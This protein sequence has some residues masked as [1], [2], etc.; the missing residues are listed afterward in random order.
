MEYV[1]P[2]L[3]FISTKLSGYSRNR[4][5]LM[6][7]TGDTATAGRLTTFNLPENA[8]IDTHNLKMHFSVATTGAVVNAATVHARLPAN[9]SSLISRLEVSINGVSVQNSSA[10]YNSICRL[11]QIG[12]SNRDRNGSV[13]RAL[14]HGAINAADEDEDL[15]LVISEW[16]GIL[17]ESST[18]FFPTSVL[19]AIQIRIT[20]AENAVLVPK[21]TGVDM[22]ANLTTDGKTAALQMKY[23]CSD[24]FM[25]C[26]TVQFGDGVYDAMLRQRLSSEEYLPI[27]F[28]DRFSF[29]ESNITGSAHMSR[30]SLSATSLDRIYACWRN[31]NYRSV[32]VKGQE[33]GDSA[34]TDALNGNYFRFRSFDS[35]VTK[36]GTLRYS[37]Q[38]NNTPH[39]TYKMDVTDSLFDLAYCHDKTGPRSSGVVP[40]SMSAFQDGLFC[41]CLSLSHPDS[42]IFMQAGY[43]SRGVASQMTLQCEGQQIPVANANTQKLASIESFIVVEVTSKLMVGLDREISISH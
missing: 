23:A 11:L 20:W 35:S 9:A 15:S 34:L 14:S 16:Q 38:I 7:A 30:F 37:F 4:F 8:T 31:S 29:S 40:T 6:P 1:P 22:K 39:P 24:I 3:R 19:G 26:D 32:G 18:R 13:D 36:A 2:N 5:K 12:D 10:E 25:T 42:G 27:S 28:K 43:D 17:N 21:E 33:L 41:A